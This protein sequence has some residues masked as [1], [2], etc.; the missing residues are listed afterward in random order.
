MQGA[1]LLSGQIG[2][3]KTSVDDGDA[4]QTN[5]EKGVPTNVLVYQGKTRSRKGPDKIDGYQNDG[6]DVVVVLHSEQQP[7]NIGQHRR[8]KR[9]HQTIEQATNEQNG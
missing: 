9:V 6:V 5:D 1:F 7:C 3:I 8:D 4:D 2:D